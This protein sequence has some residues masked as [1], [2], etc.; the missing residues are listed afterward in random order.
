MSLHINFEKATAASI[1]TDPPVV[2]VSE[3]MEVYDDTDVDET[4]KI[5]VEQLI[6]RIESCEMNGSGWIVSRLIALDTTVWLLDA[7]R[8]RTFHQ[9]PEWIRPKKAVRNNQN[10]DNQCFKWAILG[11]LYEPTDHNAKCRVSSDTA[12]YI[13]GP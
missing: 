10:K 4:S 12:C 7:L 9:L 1:V 3:Q 6:N 2:L 5:T 8:G 11:V 13:C